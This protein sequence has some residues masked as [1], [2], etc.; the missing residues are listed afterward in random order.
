MKERTLCL[1]KSGRAC[2]NLWKILEF[3]GLHKR[4]Q[5]NVLWSFTHRVYTR[6]Y[7]LRPS[8]KGKTKRSLLAIQKLATSSISGELTNSICFWLWNMDSD[9]QTCSDSET[10]Y[11]GFFFLYKNR[12]HKEITLS[13]TKIPTKRVRILTNRLFHIK[14][15]NR[16]LRDIYLQRCLNTCSYLL[17]I[18]TGAVKV[19]FL[20]VKY[21]TYDGRIWL[22]SHGNTFR[23]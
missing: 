20:V 18:E 6:W 14:F 17:K 9:R 22:V 12:I 1:K 8:A 3:L 23:C 16:H 4:I 15:Y 21:W 2:L 13:Y 10:P 5:M 11:G 19:F 7:L